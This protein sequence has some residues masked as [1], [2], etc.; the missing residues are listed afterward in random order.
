M[1]EGGGLVGQ[2]CGELGSW[3]VCLC[4]EVDMIDC[5]Y[6]QGICGYLAHVCVFLCFR[7]YMSLFSKKTKALVKESLDCAFEE[8]IG[9]KCAK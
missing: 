1:R 3:F 6:S 4:L 9:Y 2:V 8:S 7:T 5:I